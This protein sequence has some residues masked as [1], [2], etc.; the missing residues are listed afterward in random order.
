M[1]AGLI[2]S[3]KKAAAFNRG[4][5]SAP[6]VILWTDADRQWE[7]V[8][9]ALRAAG[10]RIFSLGD[11]SADAA[12]GPAIWLKC[13]LANRVPEYP[14]GDGAVPVL[15]LPGVSRSDL[16][17]IESCPRHLQPLAELQYR[18][19]FWSQLNAKDWTVNA[20]LT[21]QN[22]GLG[23]DVAQDQSTQKALLRALQ[24]GLLLEQKLDAFRGR[25]LDGVWFDAL[26]APNPDRDL[27]AW[28]NDPAV[29]RNSWDDARWSIFVER[30]RKDYGFHPEKDGELTGAEKMAA[31]LGNWKETWNL[32]D[33]LHSYY[34]NIRKLLERVV[35]LP[36][37]LFDD[38]SSYPVANR[39]KEDQ[40]RQALLQ[41]GHLA[42]KAGRDAVIEAEQAHGERRKWLW[43]RMGLAPLANSLESLAKIAMMTA[44]LPSGNSLDAFLTDY[45][46][47]FWLVDEAALTALAKVTTKADSSAVEAALKSIYVP[48]LEECA[49]R[50]QDMVR[51]NGGL[52]VENDYPFASAS[53]DGMCWI[54]VDGLR[55][56]VARRLVSLLEARQME[57]S[58]TTNWTSIPSVTASGKVWV[59]PVAP[60]VRGKPDDV[61]FQPSI[62]SDGKPL[63]TYNFRR[64]L[65]DANWQVLTQNEVGDAAGRAWTECG[66]LDHYGHVHGLRLAREIDAQL[67]I[68]I[69][70]LNELIQAGWRHLRI[71]TDHGWLLVPGG[72]PK[73]ILQKFEA[74]T[75]WGRCATLKET[76]ASSAL[77]LPW[78]WCDDVRIAFAPGISSFIAGAEYAHGGLSVQEMLIPTIDIKINSFDSSKPVAVIKQ[79]TWRGLRCQVEITGAATGWLCDIRTK[80]ADQQTSIVAS[81]KVLDNG[82]AS[83]A[84]PDDG[85][86]GCVAV[87]VIL[88][89][90]GNVVQKATTTVGE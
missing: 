14:V 8:L 55:F 13:V 25:H 19:V 65:S 44:Q 58:L 24:S 37:G 41:S 52:G 1:L 10:M 45:R 85:L 81:P 63:S 66:D 89:E 38:V 53:A 40:L 32:Y 69:E 68:I 59:S 79:I 60:L 28:L 70:R 73:A 49:L 17:A 90:A 16:R 39:E 18:G 20:F 84:V 86:E 50:F 83:L 30:C 22:G 9:P 29:Q 6:V 11:Y 42:P 12:R 36:M 51:N 87:L 47:R 21:S 61:D 75:R 72:M 62:A 34:P 15:Y 64:L 82:C 46:E 27:L 67:P 4:T 88:D 7:G 48:W 77:T 2:E 80:A 71:V 56:D 54:F 43:S 31:R 23:L 78:T 3:L 74:E 57:P 33:E 76:S 35:A 26:L 5:Q